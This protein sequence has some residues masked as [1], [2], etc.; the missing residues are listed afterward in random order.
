MVQYECQKPLFF[1]GLK[2]VVYGLPDT[3][4]NNF[5]FK[6]LLV[7]ISFKFRGT[8]GISTRNQVIGHKEIFTVSRLL[9][10]GNKAHRLSTAV[11]IVL[12]YSF[13]L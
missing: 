1:D 7:D 4:L 5:S 9:N 2:Y 3:I 11:A 10:N 8:T 12:P 6:E 13:S